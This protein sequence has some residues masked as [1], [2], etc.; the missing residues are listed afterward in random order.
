M[1]IVF[2]TGALIAVERRQRTAL[3][4]LRVA[5]DDGDELGAL[6]P[7]VVVERI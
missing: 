3:E 6:F 1:R 7:N 2:D 4:V 5:A